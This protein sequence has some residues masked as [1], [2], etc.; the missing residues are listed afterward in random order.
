MATI[1]ISSLSTCPS[2]F[3]VT[4]ILRFIC[5]QMTSLYTYLII[6]IHL[7][8]AYML[9]HLYTLYAFSHIRVINKTQECNT[10]PRIHNVKYH[11]LFYFI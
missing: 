8:L 9:C 6:H 10:V 4:S 2:L 5:L 3:Y 1:A 7:P 11:L